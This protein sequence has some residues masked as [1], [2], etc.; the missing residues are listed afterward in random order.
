M[1]DKDVQLLKYE[2]S[3]T[4]QDVRKLQEDVQHLTSIVR[5]STTTVKTIKQSRCK[6]RSRGAERDET[7]NNEFL[8]ASLQDTS[9]RN[10]VVEIDGML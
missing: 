5:E 6:E 2:P 3:A 10:E 9:Y 4:N 8:D 7:E 1:S